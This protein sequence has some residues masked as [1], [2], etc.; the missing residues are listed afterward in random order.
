MTNAESTRRRRSS[1]GEDLRLGRR[2]ESAVCTQCASEHLVKP[3]HSSTKRARLGTT[4]CKGPPSDRSGGLGLVGGAA[5]DHPAALQLVE[6]TPDA[7]RL[8]DSQG[9]L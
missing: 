4:V 8:P 5:T 7:V 1:G 6:P 2:S 9:V 3:D